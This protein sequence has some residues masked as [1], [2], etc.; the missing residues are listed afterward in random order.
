MNANQGNNQAVGKSM[1]RVDGR[2]KV[3]GGA[4]YA[5][6]FP[7]ENLAHAVVVESTIARGRITKID[8][9][10][11]EKSPGVLAVITHLNAPKLGQSSGNRNTSGE[12]AVE[13]G[14]NPFT[15][16]IL[17]L[18]DTTITFYGQHIGVVIAET[19]E[20]AKYAAD[21]VKVTYAKETPVVSLEKNLARAYKPEK[22]LIPLEPDSGR[23]DI[24]Q[25]LKEADVQ[26]DE[27]YSTPVEHHNPM[28]SSATIAVWQGDRLTLYD[29]S[30]NVNGVQTTVA[31]TLRIPPQ[32]IQ[33]ISH[34]VGG[35]FGC[36]YPAKSHNILAAIAAQRVKR[37]VKLVLTRQQMFT[38][39]GC[40]PHSL[41]RIRLGAKKDG[42]LTAVAH[43]ITTQTDIAREFIEH[44]GAGTNMMY[45]TPNILVAHRAVPLNMVAPTIMRAPGETPG[46]Y[47]LESGMDEL[48]YK[49]GIDPVELRI[50]N[51]PPQDPE[52]NLPWSSRSLVQCLQQGAKRFGWEKRNPKPRSMQEG[53]YLIGYGVASATYPANRRPASARTRIL[54]DGKVLVQIAATD[55][56]TGTYTI[57]TQVAA[58]ALGV[59]PEQVRVEIGDTQLPPSPGSGGSWGA[60]SYGSA[61]QEC[62]VAARA[63]VLAL[64]QKDTRSSLKGLSDGD[65]E[66]RAGR[67]VSKQDSSKGETYQE[68]LTRNNLKEVVAE[69]ESKPDGA[70]KKYSMHS[71]G[72]HF[73]EV[74]VDQDLGEVRVS[75]FLGVFGAGRILNP[76]TAASQMIGGIVWGIGMALH[77]ETVIDER[78]GHFV[79]HNLGE[80]HVPVNADIPNIEVSF[81]EEKDP[82]VNPLG[83]KGVGEIGIVGAA[84]A[85]ANAVYH[86]TGKR[87]RDLPMTPDKLL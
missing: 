45:S 1:N 64:V 79:N 16:P 51:D 82:H 53:R 6:E 30:Q 44:V 12:Q 33:V 18:Q 46:M 36:K 55:I 43:E 20:Q 74:R 40:R 39:V 78:Y 66:V 5:A 14:G 70:A 37:P 34:Y 76:K 52:K 8:T 49:L 50:I 85:V 58:E 31:N 9:S 19:L 38:S 71:F 11:A 72:A 60:A 4:R 54:S 67:I 68:I 26:V 17:V 21:L 41:Q 75:R 48:A 57:L 23:G 77:E 28:E 83:V 24:N 86:A 84:A 10:A 65:M 22:L 29:A 87:I 81:V 59:S 63:K 73:A 27:T 7:T 62:C 61:V 35:G 13:G 3:T 80:Y 56:G 32:N 47:A 69:V 2:L 42:K 25:G 15:K